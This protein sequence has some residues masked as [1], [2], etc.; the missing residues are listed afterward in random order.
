MTNP[1]V[2]NSVGDTVITY[3]HDTYP[4]T[5]QTEHACEFRLLSSGEFAE[6]AATS[7]AVTLYLYNVTKDPTFKNPPGRGRGNLSELVC[8]TGDVQ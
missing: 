4:K 1:F 8:E 2:I 7:I 3:L 5:L 6:T